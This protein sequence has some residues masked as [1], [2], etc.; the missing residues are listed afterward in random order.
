MA[1]ELRAFT[2]DDIDAAAALLAARHREHRSAEPLLAA[3]FT[4]D[5]ATRGEVQA[6]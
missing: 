6:A 5:E 3:R 1:I 2:A 4:E